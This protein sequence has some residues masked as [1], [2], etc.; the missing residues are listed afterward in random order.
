MEHTKLQT[1]L[2]PK[3]RCSLKVGRARIAPIPAKPRLRCSH[4]GCLRFFDSREAYLRHQRKHR[5]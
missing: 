2:P 4:M 5:I 1:T 3:K